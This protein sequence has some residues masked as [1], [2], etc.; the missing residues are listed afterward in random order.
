MTKHDS[1]QLL[2]PSEATLRLSKIAEGM[3]RDGLDY[4]LAGDNANLFYLTGRVF[5][6]YILISR[7]AQMHIWLRRPSSLQ[8]DGIATYRRPD[9]LA[10]GIMQVLGDGPV[11]VGMTLDD[12]P[13]AVI[14][15]TASMLGPNVTVANA[16]GALRGARMVKTPFEAAMLR[17][18]GV[19]QTE[20]YRHIPGVYRPGMTDIE[21]QIEIERLLR[22]H[23]CLGLFRTS[24]TDMEIFMGSV[25][26]GDNADT[27]SPYDFAMGGAG[28]SPSAPVGANGSEIMPGK[29][30]MVDMCGNFNGYQ[31]DMTRCFAV[32]K[33]DERALAA[34]QLSIDICDRLAQMMTPG[35]PC[36]DLYAE[37]ER[38]VREAGME[39]YFMGHRQQAAFVGH[40]VGVTLNEG[41]VIAPRSRNVIEAGN[42]IAVEPKFVIPGIGAVGIENTYLATADGAAE[43][44]TNAPQQIQTLSDL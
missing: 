11:T 13:Y 17:E 15:R 14:Q 34:N 21:F 4:I 39:R 28:L 12:T 27:P 44:L 41:P 29:P 40:G 5:C 7:D 33:P 9:Q 22:L 23:G 37:A 32:G 20:A 42:A 25:L 26:T 6:G 1:L 43:C 10:E 31:T 16:C 19:K 3:E 2:P 18:C 24:G 8:A 35:T 36:R 30:V 38:M